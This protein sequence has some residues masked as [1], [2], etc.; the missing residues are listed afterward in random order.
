MVHKNEKSLVVHS[1]LVSRLPTNLEVHT[2]NCIFLVSSLKM[3]SSR[4]FI[5]MNY[6]NFFLWCFDPI[7]VRVLLLQ[8]FAITVIG[9]TT[10]GRAPMDEWSAQCIEVYLTTHNT[11]KRHASKGIQTHTPSKQPSPCII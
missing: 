1:S 10:L 3:H 6:T 4:H 11:H 7:L 5:V 8:G 9:H 2:V